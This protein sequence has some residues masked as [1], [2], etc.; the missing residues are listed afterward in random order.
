MGVMDVKQNMNYQHVQSA[1]PVK[2]PSPVVRTATNHEQVQNFAVQLFRSH[3][4]LK[5]IADKNVLDTIRVLFSCVT[6]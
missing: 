6:E 2:T 4:D 5:S 3:L 1:T